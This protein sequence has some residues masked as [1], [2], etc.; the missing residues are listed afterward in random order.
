[1]TTIFTKA[2]YIETP[3]GRKYHGDVVGH[4]FIRDVEWDKDRMKIFDAWSIHPEAL[5]EIKSLGVRRL[6]YKTS[7]KIYTIRLIDAQRKGFVK[8]FAGGTTHYVQLKHW[9]VEPTITSWKCP[10]CEND[11]LAI[12]TECTICYL[13]R[14]VVNEIKQNDSETTL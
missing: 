12:N 2:I 9:K 6:K 10:R 5:K 13:H 4:D 8:E 7:D 11:N 1:M 14:P 3:Q